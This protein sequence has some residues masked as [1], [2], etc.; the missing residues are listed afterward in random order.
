MNRR[1]HM[2]RDEADDA[3]LRLHNDGCRVAVFLE[4]AKARLGFCWCRGIAELP[5][6]VSDGLGVAGTS[7]SHCIRGQRFVLSRFWLST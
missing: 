7:Q 2:G 6:E 5:E 3:T 1:K 4:S